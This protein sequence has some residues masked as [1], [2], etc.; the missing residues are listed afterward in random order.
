M[1]HL[2]GNF[3]DFQIYWLIVEITTDVGSIVFELCLINTAKPRAKKVWHSALTVAGLRNDPSA[4][5][6]AL[7]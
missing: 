4:S 1:C 3:H 5:C 6:K 7:P 2:G